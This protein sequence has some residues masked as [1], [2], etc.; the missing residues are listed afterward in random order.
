MKNWANMAIDLAIILILLMG[1]WQF[2][3]PKRAL[4]GNLTAVTALFCAFVLLL[5]R[6]DILE[7]AI[8]V[9]ALFIG[10]IV[11][12]IVAVCVNMIQI[13]AMI[14][15][16]HGAGGTAAFL[17]SFIEL[18]RHTTVESS[19][20]AEISGIAGL[21]IGAA[22]FSASMIASGK[23]AS[24]LKQAP[25]LLPRHGLILLGTVTLIIILGIMAGTSGRPIHKY[26]FLLI[27]V[28]S[29]SL[30]IIFSIRIGGAD[31]PILI[32]FLNATAGIAAAFCGIIIHNR[33][34]IASGATVAASGSVLTHFMCK[35]MSRNIFKV[36]IGIQHQAVSPPLQHV[37][38]DLV[39]YKH[40]TPV[41]SAKEDPY[42]VASDILKGAH[43]VIIIPGYGMALAQ[44]QLKVVELANRLE[45][46]G[47]D[48]KFAIH[49]VAGRM[50]G[51]MNVLL[52][53]ANVSYDKLSEIEDINPE[54]TNTDVALITGACDVVNPA[55]INTE[56]TP[57]SGMPILMAH[58]AKHVIIC[59]LDEKPG[60]SGVQNPLYSDKK[61]IMLL[62]DA[63]DTIS[64]LMQNLSSTAAD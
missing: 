8:V 6:N 58:E 34:L 7:L 64:R 61:T 10:S 28:A 27:I 40:T 60:Y 47:K 46:M 19:G 39:E 37:A 14:A 41:A 22:T 25:T 50:P 42:R 12:W 55:A 62:G 2:K 57:L 51:H 1:I 5:Y 59:N 21:I 24:K 13:P 33:L 45:E 3:S 29:I 15:F 38:K 44:A 63:K 56:G 32:S 53:E 35:A 48:V 36:F 26:L 54:F 9:I 4:T 23:L 16:Q 18:T 17:V 11:G 43:K 52:A 49:P 30:G 31:M 20:V